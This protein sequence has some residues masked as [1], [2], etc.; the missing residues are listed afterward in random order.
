MLFGFFRG[1]FRVLFRVRLTGNTQALHGERVLIV[2][3][4]V[5]FIDGIL[6][7]LFLP[8]RPVFAVY[9]SISQ[10]WYMRWLKPIIDFVPLD[11]TKPMSVKHLVRL[12]GEGRPVV[13]FP[14]GRISVSGSLMKIYD[15]AGFVAAK[16]AAT[17]VPLRIEGAELTFFSRLK[18]LVKQRLFPQIHLHVL[19]P[20]QLPM[21]EA[22]RARDRRKI[23]GEM[24]HQIMMEARMAVRPRETLFDAFLAAQYRYGAGKHCVEDIN[25]T[26]DTYRKL[27]TKTLFVARILDKY[28]AQGEKIGLMLPNAGISAA[29]IFGAIARG[30]IPAMMNYTAGVKG[31]TSAITAAEI[32]TVF[33]SRTFMDKGKLWHLPEQLTQVRWVYLEDLKGSVTLED[34]LWIFS[35]VLMPRLAQV[36]QK[37]EDAAIILFT[38]GSEGNP[39]G[40]VHSHKSILANVEQIRTIADFTAND[41]FMSALPLFHSFGLTVGL[42]TPLLTGAEVFL[43]PSPL[44]YRIVPE[45]VY[46]RNCT[47]LFGTSTF[48]GNYARFANPYDFFRLRYVVAGAEKLQDSTRQLWQ[49]KFGLR[50][51]E[52]YGVTECAP[53]VSINVPMAA[54]PGTVGRILPGMDARLLEVPGIDDGGRLQLKGPN[55]M[56]GYLRVEKP[57]VLEAPAAENAQGELESGWYDTGDIVRFDEQ[58]F[59]QIQGRAKRFAKIAGEMISLEMVEQLALAVSPEKMHATAIK[60][61]AS[62]GEALVLFTTDEQLTREKL[63]QQARAQG[64]PELAVPRDIRFL[65]QLPLLGSGKPDF[66]TLKGMVEEAETQNA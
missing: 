40:V 62:K 17:V 39:K 45:L 4:H 13:I 8:V 5:S 25:F 43:Y 36:P 56:N 42:F 14:E 60:S 22:P 55:I 7:A 54:K 66:V 44:H 10:Q 15:G 1:L 31:L 53:V 65:K 23:A 33:T 20:T 6:L 38:S 37:P 64:V 16:S 47:V 50:I 21:P 12:I 59:V 51:L 32:K 63:Q 29:V 18:G 19:P 3:N 58:G 24:L 30:R 57:G 61:D 34:K 49:D 46:D 11:P 52:G 27:L 35:R 26:P 41:R 28:T 2:P 9:T 48:L